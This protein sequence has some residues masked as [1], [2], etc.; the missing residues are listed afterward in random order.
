MSTMKNAKRRAHGAKGERFKEFHF[1][2]KLRLPW[3]TRLLGGGILLGKDLGNLTSQLWGFLSGCNPNN[4]PFHSK[5]SMNCNVS[6]SYNIF[7]LNFGMLL[8]ELFR[9]ARSRLT[10]DHQ[11]LK[12]S[13]L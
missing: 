11:L 4:R 12:D 9:K 1:I 3:G 2:I 8:T 5:V 7:P 10:D 13:T 6:E